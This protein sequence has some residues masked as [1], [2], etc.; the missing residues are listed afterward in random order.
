MRFGYESK[1]FGDKNDNAREVHVH[2]IAQMLLTQLQRLREVC[3]IRFCLR[4]LMWISRNNLPA[5]FYSLP[6]AL[7]AMF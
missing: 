3:R 1:W 2:N 4:L 6:T 5:P 7:A